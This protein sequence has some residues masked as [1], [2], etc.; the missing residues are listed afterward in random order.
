LAIQSVQNIQVL[1]WVEPFPELM[2]A[3]VVIE[4]FGCKLPANYIVAMAASIKE[5]TGKRWINLEYLSAEPWVAGCHKLPSPHP[6]LPLTKYFFFPGF[7]TATGGL[8]RE[9]NLF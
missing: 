3:D 9:T 1:H 6:Y 7:T 2:P 8:I 4:A 5:K